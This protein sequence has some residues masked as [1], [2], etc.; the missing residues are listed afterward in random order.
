MND[1]I[2]EKIPFNVRDVLEDINSNILWN[3][4][5]NLQQENERLKMHNDNL[6]R[7]IDEIFKAVYN[8]DGNNIDSYIIKT[9]LLNILVFDYINGG[10]E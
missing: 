8:L 3:Y 7:K 9:S 4:I 6:D 2:K 1:E 10:K 5:N